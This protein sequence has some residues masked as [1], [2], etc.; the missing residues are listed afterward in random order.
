MATTVQ[1]FIDSVLRLIQVLDAG[2]S[3]STTEANHALEVL[4]QMLSSWTAAGIPIYQLTTESISLTGAASYTLATRPAQI[5]AVQSVSA[6]ITQDVQPMTAEQWA[7]L[8]DS[9][10]TG[11]FAT[12]YLYDNGWPSATIK[13]W[14]IP[15]T[16]GTLQLY[17]LQPLA[18]F[19]GLGAA[20]NLPP[21][22]EQA[23]RFSLALALAPEYGS[24]VTPEIAGQAQQ[25]MQAIASLNAAVLG[26]P[27]NAAPGAPPPAAAAQ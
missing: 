13:L 21:G 16:G 10:L 7:G 27:R 12:A 19:A 11:K 8:R 24:V 14:P 1:T 9:T 15:A 23:L 6:G 22:Y 20:I 17:T 18:P 25:A 4:N 5:K 3:S 26:P 2:E